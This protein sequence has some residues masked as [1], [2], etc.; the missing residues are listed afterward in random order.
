MLITALAYVVMLGLRNQVKFKGFSRAL[1]S[2]IELDS[3]SIYKQ[4]KSSNR[5]SLLFMLD[6]ISLDCQCLT[7]YAIC[8]S[9]ISEFTIWL[10]KFTDIESAY[11]CSQQTIGQF[12]SESCSHLYFSYMNFDYISLTPDEDFTDISN[13]LKRPIMLTYINSNTLTADNCCAREVKAVHLYFRCM[14]FA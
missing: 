4:F 1:E 6:Y 12:G 13:V 7:V 11:C 10:G 8:Q 2:H 3:K 5:L 14:S 9:T